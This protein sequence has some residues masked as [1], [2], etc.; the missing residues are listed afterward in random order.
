M[1]ARIIDIKRFA[2]HDGKGIRTTVFFKG[3]P[4][5]C[6]W[7]HNPESIY[8]GKDLWIAQESCI[9]C[10][11]CI[12]CPNNAI[13]INQSNHI[14]IDKYKCNFCGYCND[15]CPSNSISRIDREVTVKEI[16][17]ELRKDQI[18][19]KVSGGGVTLSG[20]EPLQQKEFSIKLLKTLKKQDIST[21]VETSMYC[22]L[23]TLKDAVKF[24]D[25]FYVDIKLANDLLHKE[26][27]GVSNKKILDNFKY[28]A[29]HAAD[30]EVRI[31]LVPEITATD[32]NIIEILKLV[33]NI[34]PNIPI[35]LL[36]YNN[37]GNSKYARLGRDC[38]CHDARPFTDREIDNINTSLL[39]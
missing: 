24:T 22:D 34:N 12:K 26:Y 38:L 29:K 16:I 39:V 21:C 19:Y 32:N 8:E 5:K 27:V 31:P 14:I 23:K 6:A 35:E 13:S 33:K 2:I 3:C 11:K 30:I 25:K 9:H 28:L 4:L 10:K 36:N 7:C 18:Y 15:I 37:L 17:D 1:K 20:G